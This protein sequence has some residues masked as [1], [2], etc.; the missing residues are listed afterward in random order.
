[1]GKNNGH[2]WPEDVTDPIY[3]QIFAECGPNFLAAYTCYLKTLTAD[4]DITPD[5]PEMDQL[6]FLPEHRVNIESVKL[7]CLI[8]LDPIFASHNFRF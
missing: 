3:R 2:N 5:F 1:M 6:N 4:P 7:Q 8:K